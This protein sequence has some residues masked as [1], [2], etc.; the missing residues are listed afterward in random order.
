M[1]K[2]KSYER[3]HGPKAGPKL[4]HALQSQAAH[5]GVSERRLRRAERAEARVRD[6][7]A[8]VVALRAEIELM[9]RSKP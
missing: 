2:K 5:A 7:E 9:R 1:R 3:I 8:E 6:L 4:H